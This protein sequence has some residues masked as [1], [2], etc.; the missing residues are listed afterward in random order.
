MSCVFER[1]MSNIAFIFPGQGSQRTGMLADLIAKEPV[2]KETLAEASDITGL[3][4]FQLINK[5]SE[6]QLNMTQNTQPVL[7]ASSVAL[8]RLWCDKQLV[9]PSIMAGHS[10]GEYSALVC[11]KALAFEDGLRLVQ[12]RGQYMQE[13][14]SDEKGAMVA[15]IGLDD[16]SVVDICS[17]IQNE[18][19]KVLAAINYNA[20]GQV[21]VAGAKEAVELSLSEFRE[22]GARKVVSLSVSV[23]SHCLLMKPAADRLSEDLCKTTV[24]KPKIPVVQNVS[25]VM[26]SNPDLIVE[27]LTKQLYSPVHW[28][29]SIQLIASKN[30]EIF[31]ECGPGKVLAGLNKRIVKGSSVV[32]M[33]DSTAF[34]V[35]SC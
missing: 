1:V 9:T 16:E 19:G 27:N 14:M 30:I 25:A 29:K 20:P 26:E 18:S 32:Y 6:D 31:Y 21:V 24:R 2:V 8:W 3:D 35:Q 17:K 5:G 13:A 23:P 12:K 22:A 34:E 10:L 28:V 15:V 11:A 33:E 4:I 7:L